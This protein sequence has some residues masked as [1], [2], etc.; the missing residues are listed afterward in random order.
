MAVPLE[1]NPEVLVRV[2]LLTL[3]L[4]LG[5]GLVGCGED[6]TLPP[7][8][9]QGHTVNKDGVAHRPGLEDPT[10]NCTACHGADLQGGTNGEPSCY[11]CHGQKW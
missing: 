6:P 3:A 2:L 11:S 5:G 8:A 1:P 9:P 4:V 7:D 10:A